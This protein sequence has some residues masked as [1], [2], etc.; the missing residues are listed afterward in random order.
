MDAIGLTFNNHINVSQNHIVLQAAIEAVYISSSR[1]F[2]PV[3]LYIYSNMCQ[4]HCD[5]CGPGII[6]S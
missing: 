6:I 5:F 4:S 1:S 2:I 3:V